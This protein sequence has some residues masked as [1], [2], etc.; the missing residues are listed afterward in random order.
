MR[1]VR[2]NLLS[3]SRLYIFLS[4]WFL[5][6][7]TYKHILAHMLILV[8]VSA[9]KSCT[10]THDPYKKIYCVWQWLWFTSY[11][12]HRWTCCDNN[13]FAPLIFHGSRDSWG[14]LKNKNQ[15][16]QKMVIYLV[17]F[18]FFFLVFTK[19]HSIGSTFHNHTNFMNRLI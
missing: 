5:T 14:V 11:Y 2:F 9:S 18:F 15:T 7:R 17:L 4:F 13:V 16:I 1:E 6:S 3:L 8:M 10:W 12:H 19:N